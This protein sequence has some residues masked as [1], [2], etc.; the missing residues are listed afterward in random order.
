MRNHT[1]P[2]RPQRLMVQLRRQDDALIVRCL[3]NDN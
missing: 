1:C 3:I 2:R